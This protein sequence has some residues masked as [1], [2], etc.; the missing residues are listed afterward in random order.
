M[1]TYPDLPHFSL[2]FSRSSGGG[3]EV[4]EQ[5]TLSHVR[6]QEHAVVATPLG[7][8]DDRP[9]FGWPVPV[10]GNLP[11]DLTDLRAALR[12]FVPGSEANLSEWADEISQA[13][14][15]VRIEE[16]GS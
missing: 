1:T 16:R 13:T 7:Y 15:H 10:F 11:L 5:D 8:R 6:S 9:D 4:N 2:P 12:Q 14:R 3:V